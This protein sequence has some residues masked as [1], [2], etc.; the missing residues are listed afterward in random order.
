M[1]WHCIQWHST[2]VAEVEHKSE[3]NL[4]KDTPYLTP[5]GKLWDIYYEDLGENWPHYIGTTL[6]KHMDIMDIFDITN[7]YKENSL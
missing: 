3:V 6:Y 5:M 7:N 2:A 1:K 4:T